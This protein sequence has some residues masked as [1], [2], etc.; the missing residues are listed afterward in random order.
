M[1]FSV[2]L[3]QLCCIY[4][5]DTWYTQYTTCTVWSQPAT[6]IMCVY[7]IV[8]VVISDFFAITNK[9]RTMP[10]G[11]IWKEIVIA[12]D[13]KSTIHVHKPTRET[14]FFTRTVTIQKSM[15]D[16]SMPM[17]VND[18]DKCS[19]IDPFISLLL[20]L[21]G[22]IPCNIIIPCLVWI[23]GLIMCFTRCIF[24]TKGRKKDCIFYNWERL[25][26]LFPRF[27]ICLL[28]D[29]VCQS[30]LTVVRNESSIAVVV[31][32]SHEIFQLFSVLNMHVLLIETSAKSLLNQ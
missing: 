16:V 4:I 9:K 22:P 32:T 8:I 6:C 23:F 17:I 15:W 5:H 28:S 19:T 30:E 20:L 26:G 18:M 27:G 7:L 10:Q 31:H 13:A 25:N 12:F 21:S 2:S 14:F 3:V 1:Y 29:D 11:N 24:S